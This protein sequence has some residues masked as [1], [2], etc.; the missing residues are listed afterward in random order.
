MVAALRERNAPMNPT[1]RA[2]FV[3][4][5]APGNVRVGEA[6]APVPSAGE[7]LVRVVATSLNRGE[8]RMAAQG[9]VGRRIGWDFAGTVERAA[10]NGTGP[11]E[12]ARV[13][14]MLATAAWAELIAAPTEVL[15]VL[16]AQVTFA[17]AATLPVAGLTALH[18]LEK[19]GSMLARKILVTGGTGGVGH[20]AIQLARAAGARVVATVRSEEK[21]AVVRAAGAHEVIVSTEPG[22]IAQHA[23]YDL[24]LDGVG[25]PV[26]GASLGRLAK[27]GLCVVYGA[28]AG[29][30][31]PFDA[32]AFYATG[33]AT[34]YGFILFHELM[35]TPAG[36]GLTRLAG[37][38]AEGKL[39][40]LI[41]IEAP[42][43]RISEVAQALTERGFVGKA[44]ITF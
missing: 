31:V 24:V 44:V 42:L 9:P 3:D 23:P 19:G 29:A 10:A 39:R 8:I 20:M 30:D 7:A 33:G 21:A 6:P 27:D 37:L 11:R 43:A 16:P 18:G 1:V 14:G 34:F 32:R 38:V 13:V 5:S 12:G 40:P 26:L 41:E 35:R 15:G 17:Q 2:V 25:G 4:P 28:T 36:V 22:A